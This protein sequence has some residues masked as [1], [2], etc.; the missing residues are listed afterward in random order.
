MP[1]MLRVQTPTT[2]FFYVDGKKVSSETFHRIDRQCPIHSSFLTKQI[3]GRPY[4]YRH[5]HT[6]ELELVKPTSFPVD[7]LE[8]TKYELEQAREQ[9]TLEKIIHHIDLAILAINTHI[10]RTTHA[11]RSS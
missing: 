1:Q 4:H 6:A 7:Y 11:K 5:W 8:R 2:N 10:K 3:P 9:R